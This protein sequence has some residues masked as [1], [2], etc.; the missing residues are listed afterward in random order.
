MRTCL[1]VSCFALML[2]QAAA[3]QPFNKIYLS[4]VSY[5]LNL[6]ELSSQTIV[7]GWGWY[8][9][10]SLLQPD[11]SITHSKCFYGDSVLNMASVKKFSNDQFYFVTSYRKDSCS[12]LGPLTLPFT[13]PALGRMDS[14]GNI[15]YLRY[16]DLNAACVNFAGDLELMTNGNAV[17]WGKE[18]RFL[19][20]ATDSL[21]NP[22]WA[23]RFDDPGSIRF[24]KELPGGDLLTGFDVEGIGACVARLDGNGNFIWCKNYMRPW[25]RM[26]DAI[27]ESDSS[28][29]ITGYAGTASH[30]KLFMMMLNDEGIVQWCRGYD[31][32]P[33]RWYVPQWSRIERTL[34]GNFAV[35]AT[36]GQLGNGNFY[37]PYLFKTNMNGDTLWT[38][39]MGAQGYTYY[40]RDLLAHSDGSFMFSGI[41]EGSL[42]DTWMGAPY[43]FRTDSLGHFS[44]SERVHPVQVLELFPTDSNFTLTSI[45]GATAHPAF[46]SDTTFA[47]LSVYDACEVANAFRPY[48]DYKRER[49]RVRPNPNTGRF[50][51]Q[52]TDPLLAESYY[53]V[54]DAMGKLLYQRPLPRG[55]QTEEVDLSRFGAG[56]YVIKFTDKEGSCHERVVVE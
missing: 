19:V 18:G 6:I 42:P 29:I 15:E 51:V 40:T 23:K 41:V 54:Y 33:Y 52:F 13:H 27:I 49:M 26:H 32:D 48:P 22:L 1:S 39:S 9:G 35:L 14:L 28:F 5:Q 44:C 38:R 50:T 17:V 55:R 20:F 7:M 24:V 10:I 25:G 3:Q 30:P 4:G 36:L 11:G 2:A 12:A 34:D 8:P 37:R 43:I 47:P 31:S 53:S 46:V 56:S 45:D 16:Y 21:G